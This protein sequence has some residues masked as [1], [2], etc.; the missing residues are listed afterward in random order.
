MSVP[1]SSPRERL[2]TFDALRDTLS[3]RYYDS[4]FGGVNWDAL[5]RAYRPRAAAAQTDGRWLGLVREMLSRLHSSHLDIG[6][7]NLADAFPTRGG[8]RGTDESQSIQ[9][10]R[11]DARVGY[12]RIAQFNEGPAAIARLDSAFAVLAAL[13]GLVV[14]VRG[15]PGG[16][17]GVA[18]RLGDY[19]LPAATPVGTFT[20]RRPS[21]PVDYSGYD[22]NEFIQLLRTNG[23]VRI[24]S[25]GRVGRPYKG[26]VALLIDGHCGSTTEAFAAVLSELHGATLVGER[27][28]G[29]MLSGT[30][31]GLPG[32][33][34]LRFPEADFRTPGG[35][36]LEGRGVLPDVV[37]KRHWYRDSQMQTAILIAGGVR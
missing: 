3:R 22:V 9:W 28:A 16:T 36:R 4:T 29:A 23:T 30:E 27:T 13:P 24:T 2:V 34:I 20:S 7:I 26:R 35:V 5:T 15:N 31:V 18:M 6:A 32:G 11:I 37:V 21:A 25:G 10:R 17:L 12:L 19:L 1:V 14:D 33:W 8:G